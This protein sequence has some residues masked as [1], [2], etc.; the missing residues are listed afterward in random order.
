MIKKRI[1]FL[2]TT[3]DFLGKFEQ[4]NVKILQNKGFEVHYAAN[5]QEP[6]YPIDEEKLKALG[7]QIHPIAIAR[8][9]FLFA[10]NEKAL[11]QILQLIR[12]YH[13]QAIH[14]HTPVGGLLGRL[15]GE[16]CREQGVVVVYTAHGFHFYKG[17][18]AVNQ[19]VYYPVEKQLARYTDILIVINEE[20]YRCARKFRLKRGGHLYKIPGEGLDT[21]RFRPLPESERKRLRNELGIAEEA[22]FLVS[23]GELNEN[24]NHGIVLEALEKLRQQQKG[25]PPIHYGICGDGFLRARLETRIRELGLA[26][27]VTLYG[28]CTNVPE[29]LGCADA[30]VFP[31]RREGLGMA[32]LESLAMGVPVIAADNRGTRE[33]MEHGKN[34]YVCRFDDVDGFARGI[35]VLRELSPQARAAMAV[36]CRDTVR[37]FDKRYAGALMQRVY[38]DVER[39]IGEA[40]HEKQ[41]IGQRHYGRV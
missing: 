25:G 7:V 17:A 10:D 38:A 18:P 21:A 34:G 3:R 19:L 12:R 13:I 16:L 35:E 27:M 28:Y 2:T 14:C 8:S 31:S 37:P 1:L 6:H 30:S 41:R 36:H 15:A 33:Y 40:E 4:G 20:D 26:D 23:V 5:M 24:K 9:P 22:F 39:R 29:I 11:R 32:G